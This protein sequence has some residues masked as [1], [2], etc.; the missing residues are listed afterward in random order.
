V[1][2]KGSQPGRR[3]TP[4]DGTGTLRNT[5]AVA[6][7]IRPAARHSLAD[8]PNARSVS[9]AESA[10]TIVQIITAPI[11][12]SASRPTVRPIEDSSLPIA[13]P[14]PATVGQVNVRGTGTPASAAASTGSAASM[15]AS[16]AA[17]LPS[18]RREA[19]RHA[20]AS[21]AS[22]GNA[23]AAPNPCSN[24][25]A[26]TAPAGPARLVAWREVAVFSDGSRGS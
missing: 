18:P 26:S 6:R 15:A 19:I 11:G 17:T 10:T 4:S 16:R 8:S 2:R 21:I 13:P 12:P 5:R 3:T 9:V 7:T 24:R 25:S 22:P 23:P 20:Q 14:S 1:R